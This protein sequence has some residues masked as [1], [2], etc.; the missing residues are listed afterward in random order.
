MIEMIR[1]VINYLSS[2]PQNLD[3]LFSQSG[4]VPYALLWINMFLETGGL[5][6]TFLPGNSVVLAAS[7]FAAGSDQ[8]EIRTL[9]LLFT[10]ST[11]MGDTTSFMLGRFFGKKYQKQTRIHFINQDHFEAAHEFFEQ[12]GKRTLIVSRF[13]PIFRGI[14]PFAAGFTQ[15]SPHIILPFLA[16]GVILW[17]LVY[18]SAGYFFGNLPAVQENFSLLIFIIIV[19]TM[20]PTFFIV[21]HSFRKFQKSVREKAALREEQEKAEGAPTGNGSAELVNDEGEQ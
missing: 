9:I 13:I 18:I 5:I 21:L 10:T 15:T 8:V 3:Q 20:I 19:I 4:L 17:N 2:L 7:A 11:F 16:A 6:F 1:D 12:N 14:M